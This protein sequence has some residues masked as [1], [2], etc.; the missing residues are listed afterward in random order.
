MLSREYFTMLLVAVSCLLMSLEAHAQS[1]VGGPD[2]VGYCDNRL[3][4]S[5]D[6]AN[7]IRE[8]VDKVVSSCQQPCK[9][10]KHALVSALVCEYRL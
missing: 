8:G 7:L 1:T 4:T 10:S 3:P 5:D 9:P 2:G 6:V